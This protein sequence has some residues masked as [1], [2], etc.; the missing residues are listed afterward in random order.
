VGRDGGRDTDAC[1][2][3]RRMAGATS[4]CA[5]GHDV[6]RVAAPHGTTVAASARGMVRRGDGR[7]HP[8]EPPPDGSRRI[9]S[10]R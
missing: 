5:A 4:A 6:R 7:R 10:Y 8:H 3:P 9:Y 2:R 1:G